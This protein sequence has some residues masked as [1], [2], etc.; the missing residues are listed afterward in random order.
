MGNS[1]IV[2]GANGFVGH[3]LI[4][5]L[6]KEGKN[7]YAIVRDKGK[8]ANIEQIRGIKILYCDMNQIEKLPELVEDKVEEIYHLAWEGSSGNLRE[9]YELQ[10]NNVMWTC[11]LIDAAHKMGVR[12]ILIAGSVTQLM[13]RQYLTEDGIFPEMSTCYAV[14]K[15]SAEYMC[16]CLCTKFGIDLCWTY[17]ANFYGAD[18]KTQNFINF[19]IQNYS[20]NTVPKLTQAEQM[21][22][23]TYVTDVAKGLMYACE[24]GYQNH[25]YYIGFGCPRPLKQFVEEVRNLINPNLD[26]GIGSKCFNGKSVDYRAIDVKKLERDTGFKAEVNFKD[27]IFRCLATLDKEKEGE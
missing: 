15:I 3:H 1:C 21:A 8:I 12:R 7:V 6:A 19:L 9:N 2:T 24:K 18:D 20:T 22:D 10:L 25:S 17:I 16:K 14:G 5:L 4:E 23:F 11:K 13:Y 26:T 27:G